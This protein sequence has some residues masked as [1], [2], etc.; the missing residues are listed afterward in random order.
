MGKVRLVVW[1]DLLTQMEPHKSICEK[2][3]GT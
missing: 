3:L 1:K 2:F